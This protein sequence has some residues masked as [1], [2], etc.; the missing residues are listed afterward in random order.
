VMTGT[1]ASL[2]EYGRFLRISDHDREGLIS[3]MPL[4]LPY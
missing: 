4:E 1:Q 2:L 3:L